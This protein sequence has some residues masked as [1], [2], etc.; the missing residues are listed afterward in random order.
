[1]AIKVSAINNMTSAKDSAILAFASDYLFREGVVNISSNDLKVTEQSP[2]AM[3]IDVE[4]GYV[5]VQN[6]AWVQG[7]NQPKYYRVEI[8]TKTGKALTPNASANNWIVAICIK[9][10]VG[11]L[12]PG[13]SGELAGTIEAVYGTPAASPVAP[14]IPNHHYV[15]GYVTYNSSHAVITNARITD[16]RVYAGIDLLKVFPYPISEGSMINGKIVTSVASNNLT[17]ALKTLAGNDPSATDPVYIQIGGGLRSVTSA[18]SIVMNAGT[19]NRF[20]SGKA[21]LTGKDVDYFLF[22]LW[23]VTNSVVRLVACPFGYHKFY[24]EFSSTSTADNFGQVSSGSPSATDPVCVIGR[25]NAILTF[26]TPNYNWSIG[27]SYIVQGPIDET[28]VLQFTSVVGADAPMT[29][30]AITGTDC[31]RYQIKGRMM[32]VMMD[33]VVTTGGSASNTIKPTHP[34]PASGD[35]G[36]VY[37]NPGFVNEGTLSLGH[38]FLVIA[39]PNNVEIRW[40]DSRNFGIGANKN[41][42]YNGEF[43]IIVP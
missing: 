23:D 7:S 6:D 32:K 19:T 20:N 31:Q 24:S 43:P 25:Y 17:V 3:A 30:S 16:L 34:R 39:N 21:E 37:Q 5:Y 11:S 15:L 22:A 36:T 14:A 35:A 4:K 8:D 40:Y 38:A 41:F 10:D 1:M 9:V 26:S 12:T 42:G 18:L 13:A 33:L 27:T 29:I 2:N 28:R